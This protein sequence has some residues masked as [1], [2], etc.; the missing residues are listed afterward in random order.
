MLAIQSTNAKKCTPNL[1]PARL[2]HNGPVND[3]DRHWKPETDE[4]GHSHAYLRGRHL[5]GAP[6]ALPLNYTGAVVHITDKNLPQ[7]QK[8]PQNQE[9]DEDDEDDEQETAEIKIAEKVGEFNEVIVWNHGGEVDMEQDIFVKGVREWVAF[10]ESM[11]GDEEVV[12]QGKRA[13]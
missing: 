13:T 9:L 8:P 2:N 1:L 6:L 7:P 12:E 5:H 10:A 3:T 11:H 4:T